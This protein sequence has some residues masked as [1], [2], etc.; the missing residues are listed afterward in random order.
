MR[1]T[2]RGNLQFPTY[3]K[4]RDI[5]MCRRHFYLVFSFIFFL[6]F[7]LFIMPKCCRKSDKAT[8]A[9]TTQ[10]PAIR[11]GRHFNQ[12]TNLA[13]ILRLI[14]PQIMS[15]LSAW[16]S[17]GLRNAFAFFFFIL[18]FQFVELLAANKGLTR[19]YPVI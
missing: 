16:V 19:V 4:I 1:I 17:T 2:Q 7:F 10:I 3:R 11:P 13:H 9:S 5:S 12:T 8:T 6:L 14:K 15:N 18:Q